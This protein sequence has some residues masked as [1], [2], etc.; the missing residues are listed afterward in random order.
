MKRRLRRLSWTLGALLG[1]LTQSA[2]AQS[3]P[4]PLSASG[5][6]SAAGPATGISS[7][8]GQNVCTL[9]VG[10][11]WSGT[12]QMQG[13]TNW[14]TIDVTPANSTTPQA[15]I[16]TNG[17]YTAVVTG[18]SQMR[19]NASAWSSGTATIAL[20][21][22]YQPGVTA[23]VGQAIYA[24][25]STLPARIQIGTVSAVAADGSTTTSVSFPS[26]F[27]SVSSV[28]VTPQNYSGTDNAAVSCRLIG[29]PTL[30][31]FTCGCVGGALNST[32]NVSYIASGT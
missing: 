24:L 10:G 15:N 7:L 32:V 26:T 14:E 25:A 2:A 3:L 13:S 23:K 11:T 28:V 17:L 18:L 19:T 9:D 5:S 1:L 31:G 29:T 8:T 4:P 20:Y 22:V 6:I 27:L 12:L 30:N 16:T 21:C